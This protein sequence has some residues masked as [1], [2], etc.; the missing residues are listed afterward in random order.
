MGVSQ[1]RQTARNVVVDD[2]L[3]LHRQNRLFPPNFNIQGR[4][5]Q[6][7]NIIGPL[8]LFMIPSYTSHSFVL[9][10]YLFIYLTLSLS[11]SFC[12]CHPLSPTCFYF[13]L[14]FYLCYFHII[15]YTFCRNTKTWP[16]CKSRPKKV[17]DNKSMRDLRV[18]FDQITTHSRSQN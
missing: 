9:S 1:Q 13:W 15:I 5:L 3:L 2:L 8:L 6:V 17:S 4:V 11:L 12:L 7:Y 18:Y 14:F 10:H 16:S